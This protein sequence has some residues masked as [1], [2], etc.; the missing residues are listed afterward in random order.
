MI[1]Y[2]RVSTDEQAR[3][4][5][6]LE[7]QVRSVTDEC[8]RRGWRMVRLIRDEGVSAKT[9]E[10]P[11]LKQALRA[12]ADGKADGIVAAKLDRLS[13]SVIDFS[14]LLDW[15][16]DLDA[17]IVA[18]DLQVDTSTAAGR[19]MANLVS[20]IA[21]WE[22][23]IIGERTAAGMA[24]KRSQ[25]LPIS[26][27]A[28]IDRPELV[29]RIKHLREREGKTLQEIADVLNREGVPTLRGGKEWRPSSVAN[30]AGA[31]RRKPRRKP[32]DL[33]QR[34]RRTR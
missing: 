30:A 16:D 1:G 12:I 20:A 7:A 27:P 10:R 11:G 19:L 2:V 21:E 25:G 4:G 34:K 17:T 9:L 24:V 6:G 32:V 5:L 8:E 26:R 31:T 18:L 23:E 29:E 22:R 28:V 33:P 3:S 14:T 15:A 13:R